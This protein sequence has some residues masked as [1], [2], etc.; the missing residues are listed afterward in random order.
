MNKMGLLAH[1]GYCAIVGTAVDND[2]TRFSV[3][4]PRGVH[5]QYCTFR[6]EVRHASR[7]TSLA[8]RMNKLSR[9][10]LGRDSRTTVRDMS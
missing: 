9:C 3:G 8:P 6:P 10:G 2:P 5:V 4:D 1:H 7:T